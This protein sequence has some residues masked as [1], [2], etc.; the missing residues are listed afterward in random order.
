VKAGLFCFGLHAG[1]DVRT[2]CSRLRL[3]GSAPDLCSSR[4]TRC[5]KKKVRIRYFL[6]GE[7]DIKLNVLRSGPDQ[8]PPANSTNLSDHIRKNHYTSYFLLY[9]FFFF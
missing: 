2:T 1:T 9:L 7:R 6:A 8:L 5:G 3:G 4:T